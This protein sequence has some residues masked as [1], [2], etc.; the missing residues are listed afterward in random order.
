MSVIMAEKFNKSHRE[1][2][3]KNLS[4]DGL[5]IKNVP[6]IVAI[7]GSDELHLPG[8]VALKIAKLMTFMK[9][10]NISEIEFDNV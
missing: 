8:R 5:L 10:N 7:D 2:V 1:V 4:R 6:Y 3:F 9:R